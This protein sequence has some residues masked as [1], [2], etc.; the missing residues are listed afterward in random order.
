LETWFREGRNALFINEYGPTEATIGCIVH[1]V[2]KENLAAFTRRPLIG[3]PISNTV[4]YILD[5]DGNPAP[6]GVKGEICV[7]GVCLGKG[8]LNREALTREKF[9]ADPFREGGRLYRTGDVG[10]WTPQGDVEYFGRNDGQIKIRGYRV[11]PGEV[12]KALTGHPAVREVHVTA[13]PVSG[14]ADELVAYTVTQAEVAIPELRVHLGHFLPDYMIPAH[15]VVLP[16]IP[17]TANG[18]IDRRALP[19]PRETQSSMNRGSVFKAP[20]TPMERTLCDIW[21]V[22][23]GAE[24]VGTADDFFSLG[25][26]SIKAIRIVARMSAAG[27]LLEVNDIFRHPAIAELA[28]KVK[29]PAGEISREPVT[30]SVPLTAIQRWLFSAGG[31]SHH[32]T[33]AVWISAGEKQLSEAVLSEVLGKIQERH[34]ALR[35]RYR[36]RGETILQENTGPECPVRLETADL[37]GEKDPEGLFR[38]IGSRT[39]GG[40]DLS[41]A[42]MMRA[43]LFRMDAGDRLLIVIH[44]LVVDGVSWRILIDDLR[45]GYALRASGEP[46]R[47]SERSDSFKAWAERI[48]E[49]AKSPDLLA[50]ME[51]WTQAAKWSPTPL[52]LAKI[53]SPLQEGDFVS[54]RCSLNREETRA[55]LDRASGADRVGINVLLLTALARAMKGWHGSERT[56]ITLEGHGREA[57]FP[58]LDVSRTVG[59]FTSLFPVVLDLSGRSKPSEQLRIIRETLEAIPKRGVGYGILHHLTP[60]ELIGRAAFPEEPEILFNYLGEFGSD[61]EGDLS[62]VR[63]FTENTVSPSF[64][65]FHPMIFEGMVT[66]GELRLSLSRN[67]H[68]L[69]GNAA[70]K[71]LSS[72]REEIRLLSLNLSRTGGKRS[73]APTAAA[74]ENA[75]PLSAGGE[76]GPVPEGKEVRAALSECG[77]SPEDVESVFPLSPMQEG[78]LFHELLEPGSSAY[79]EQFSFP[80]TGELDPGLL[81]EALNRIPALHDALR[82]LFAHD[83]PEEPLQV[84]LKRGRIP[85]GV[86]DLRPMDGN[87][88]ERRLADFR[89]RDRKEG[90]NLGRGPLMRFA[91]FR[92]GEA[93]WEAVWSHHHIVLDGWSNGIIVRELLSAYAALRKNLRPELSPSPPYSRYVRWLREA[94]QGESLDFWK[95]YLNGCVAASGLPRVIS[96]QPE[97]YR[98]AAG[99]VSLTPAASAGIAS[100]AANARA[101]VSTAVQC[102][103][104]VLLG[105]YTAADDVVFGAV[106]SGRP[107]HLDGVEKMV[108]LF[109]NTVPVRVSA[110]P[111]QA[112]SDLVAVVQQRGLEAAA[113]HHVPFVEI[114]QACGPKRDLV[115][116]VVIFQN[117]P[118]STEIERIAEELDTGF[119]TGPITGF[120]RPGFD[121]ALEVYPGERIR[122]FLKYNELVYDGEEMMRV[123]AALSKISEAV[124]LRPDITMAELRDLTAPPRRDAE[125]LSEAVM[126]QD[127]VF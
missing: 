2:R 75:V 77:L 34:D 25:G 22:V 100:L 31:P 58:D 64:R 1:P 16:A 68:V 117:Y 90:F 62:V 109:L 120:E 38:E 43:V 57:L 12:E 36:I 115:D 65:R 119:K 83:L 26:D 6:M 110:R 32:Y 122:F 71:L 29:K 113:H 87:D 59:W 108:G 73:A 41:E 105:A 46:I 53:S 67:R 81:E 97:E 30:G 91:L 112:F 101:T 98:G 63:E 93:T 114:R 52:P 61:A 69:T 21:R 4:V 96:G 123:L 88:Q 72:F 102:L 19:H 107:A 56:R 125:R 48:A 80:L 86:E 24:N 42:P 28:G 37:Q 74:G 27:H 20:E 66:E 103:W 127:E 51:Y 78:M 9:I 7:G 84:V 85:L 44:H 99:S 35:M 92:T 13:M 45:S 15:F 94:R 33:Q 118:L 121:L 82:T 95:N 124:S 11:E 8:Y 111:D 79:F 106:V 126:D 70:E 18:K 3:K 76:D 23:L 5:P 10:R 50:E 47:L 49:Y 89:E 17:L 55:V 14:E 40:I 39:A 104:G 54:H 116:H 60:P